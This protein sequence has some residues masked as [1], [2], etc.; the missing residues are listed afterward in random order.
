MG[1]CVGA[2]VHMSVRCL[3]IGVCI[4]ICLCVC[5]ILSSPPLQR[6]CLEIRFPAIRLQI[7]RAISLP[8]L[9][10]LQLRVKDGA[11]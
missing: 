1:V 4:Y 3:Y 5:F 6:S 2:C 9:G 10:V 8:S 11:P 7:R